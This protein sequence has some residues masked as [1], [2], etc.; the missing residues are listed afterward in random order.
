MPSKAFGILSPRSLLPSN[1]T[2]E[3]MVNPIA[4]TAKCLASSNSI[5][6]LEILP[7][8]CTKTSPAIEIAIGNSM[9]IT[10]GNRKPI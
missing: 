10:S 3:S 4:I 8:I 9:P 1:P 7:A 6:E 5:T 2:P